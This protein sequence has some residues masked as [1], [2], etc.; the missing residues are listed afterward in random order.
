M[1]NNINNQESEEAFSGNPSRPRGW[2]RAVD[3]TRGSTLLPPRRV[4]VVSPERGGE[5]RNGQWPARGI[6][7]TY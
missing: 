2:F 7:D 1:G 5:V 6:T 3:E 4:A